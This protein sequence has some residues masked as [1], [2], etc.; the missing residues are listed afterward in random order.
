MTRITA[1]LLAAPVI[2][3]LSLWLA[4]VTAELAGRVL[5]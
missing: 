5:G 1:W 3:A 2:V 4:L